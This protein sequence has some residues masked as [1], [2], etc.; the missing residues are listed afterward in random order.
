M[1]RA[2]PSRFSCV[3]LAGSSSYLMT[4]GLPR[5]EVKRVGDERVEGLTLSS[6]DDEGCCD[7]GCCDEG[8]C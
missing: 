4:D 2:V 1:L 6:G 7:E 3:L 5:K 8:C